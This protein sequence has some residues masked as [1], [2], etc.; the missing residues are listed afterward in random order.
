M[1][2]S[3]E[4]KRQLW[5][6]EG[7]AHGFVVMSA[8]AEFLYKTTDYWYPK[9]ERSIMWNDPAIGI[10]WPIEVEPTLSAKDAAGERLAD[11]GVF[12]ISP[13]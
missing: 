1:T 2:L 9:H 6:P 10:E 13:F 5:V 4:N 12:E 7:F 8:Y 3:A 11:A